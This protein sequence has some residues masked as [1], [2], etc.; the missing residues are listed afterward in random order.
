MQTN[1]EAWIQNLIDTTPPASL[2]TKVQLQLA[3]LKPR[4]APPALIS[5]ADIVRRCKW[6]SQL[7]LI[8]CVRRIAN[9][10]QDN[11]AQCSVVVL[12]P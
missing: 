8:S 11:R 1:N 5:C 10:R 2:P 9:L 12:N 4:V 3:H 7:A 6:A